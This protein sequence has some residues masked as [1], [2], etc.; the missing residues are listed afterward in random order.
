M[1]LLTPARLSSAASQ[2]LVSSVQAWILA[3]CRPWRLVLFGSGAREELSE[4]SDLDLALVFLTQA[5]LDAARTALC[6]G[7]RPVDW[8]LDL[9]FALAPEAEEK[10]RRGGV[11]QLIREEGRVLFSEV[12]P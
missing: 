9:L 2:E 11:W 5:E 12:G 10:A 8:P 3:R 6:S 7:P 4:A 1:G